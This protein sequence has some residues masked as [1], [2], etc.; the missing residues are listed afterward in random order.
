MNIDRRSFLKRARDLAAAITVGASGT[1]LFTTPARAWFGAVLGGLQIISAFVQRPNGLAAMM[2]AINMKLDLLLAEVV[3]I[4]TALAEIANAIADLKEKLPEMLAT[5]FT[6]EKVGRLRSAVHNWFD[7][8]IERRETLDKLDKTRLGMVTITVSTIDGI[9]YDL[10]TNPEGA[11]PRAAIAAPLALGTH[12]HI[13]SLAEPNKIGSALARHVQWH[14]NILSPS[15]RNSVAF[16][17]AD[18]TTQRDQVL[19]EISKSPLAKN[20]GFDPKQLKSTGAGIAT[21]CAVE[22]KGKTTDY[23]FGGPGD[24]DIY[25]QKA[26]VAYVWRFVE[27]TSSG[28]PMLAIEK[29]KPLVL[30]EAPRIGDQRSFAERLPSWALPGSRIPGC[31]HI[32]APLLYSSPAIQAAATTHPAI[33]AVD[34]EFNRFLGTPQQEGLIPKLNNLNG[35]I[36]FLEQVVEIVQSTRREA[37]RM[38]VEFQK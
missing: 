3:H 15:I 1:L 36:A 26:T 32:H 30:M 25:N 27:L 5:A 8:K 34:A 11:I 4:E 37:Q 35:R 21:G 17:L 38:R 33:R 20:S 2:S 23:A 19:N 13:L 28:Y 16:Q 9:I 31:E 18:L 12:M 6:E 29:A 24:K 22:F 10:A 14:D 7:E